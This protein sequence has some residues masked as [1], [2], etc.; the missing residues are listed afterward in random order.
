[1]GILESI[2]EQAKTLHKKIALP[3]S[4]DERVL[5]AAQL[6]VEEGIASV[7]LLGEEAIVR[8][9]AQS[10]GVDLSKKVWRPNVQKVRTLVNGRIQRIS[11]CTSCL[12]AGKVKKA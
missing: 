12:K 9:Q 3:E 7:V 11:V 5:K 8:K 10:L 4:G 6:A 2:R 1:M